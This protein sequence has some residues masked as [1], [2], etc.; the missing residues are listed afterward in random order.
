MRMPHF[1][2]GALIT[3]M[4]AALAAMTLAANAAAD[5]EPRVELSVRAGYANAGSHPV[6]TY[7]DSPE[8]FPTLWNGQIAPYRGSFAGELAAGWRFTP[9]LSVGAALGLRFSSVDSSVSLLNQ[10]DLSR[11][12]WTLAGYVKWTPALE[13]RWLRPWLSLGAGV[14][15]DSQSFTF[16]TE[17]ETGPTIFRNVGLALPLEGGVGFP[18]TTRGLSIGPFASYTPVI[19]LAGIGVGVGESSHMDAKTYGVWAVGLEVSVLAL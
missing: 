19:G 1:P 11:S 18:I 12:A 14:A 10:R 13:A 9:T 8:P 6:V 15:L 7:A 2:R 4:L 3:A 17:S 16:V 5:D